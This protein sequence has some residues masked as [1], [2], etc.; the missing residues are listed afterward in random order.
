MCSGGELAVGD[1]LYVPYKLPG[2]LCSGFNSLESVG[3]SLC[4]CPAPFII[5]IYCLLRT[6]ASP[7]V[8]INLCPK[9]VPFSLMTNTGRQHNIL[10][11][12]KVPLRRGSSAS[13]RPSPTMLKPN[14]TSIIAIPGANESIGFVKR[15]L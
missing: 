12:Q 2:F 9:S 6:G 3:Y 14:T 7:K 13:R 1:T 5:I 8:S 15:N 10:S 4:H 11:A